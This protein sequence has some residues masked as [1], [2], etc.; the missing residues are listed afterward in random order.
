MCVCVCIHTRQ[1]GTCMQRRQLSEV[2]AWWGTGRWITKVDGELG[3]ISQY[4]EANGSQVSCCPGREFQVWEEGMLEWTW[5]VVDSEQTAVNSW[6][7]VCVYGYEYIYF[8]YI[9]K[10]SN[11]YVY[12]N[13][14]IYIY[15][16]IFI[17]LSKKRAW[18]SDTQEQWTYLAPSF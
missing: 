5:V 6:C 14:Y 11:M 17:Y 4:I 1:T 8:A 3:Q 9:C 16:S 12:M 13:I 15:I 10:T 7:Y 2:A 18:S